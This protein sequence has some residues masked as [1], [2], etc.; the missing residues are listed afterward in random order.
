VG[1]TT[2]TTEA[3]NRR[4]ITVRQIMD[5]YHISRA[6][7]YR[8]HKSGELPGFKIRNQLRF[9]PDDVEAAL[10]GKPQTTPAQQ[11]AKLLDPDTIAF[12]SELA[13]AAPTLSEE[14]RDTIRAAFRA[15][16]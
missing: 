16:P 7:V 5:R 3:A 8:L 11:R 9:W 6:L 15:A 10:T 4:A 13:A 2:T 12:L 1:T 14:Q